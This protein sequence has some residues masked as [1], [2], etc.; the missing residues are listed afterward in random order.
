MSADT[1]D[2]ESLEPTSEHAA[3]A[4]AHRGYSNVVVVGSSAGG[5]EAL[6]TILAALPSDF[7][8]PIVIAQHLDP[9]RPSQLGA[10]LERKST[11]PVSVV[12]KPTKLEAG[13]AYVVASNRHV[14]IH[15]GYVTPEGDH[16]GRPRPSIDLLLSTAAASY[17]ENLIAV[18]LTGSGSDGAA[19]AL[20]VK[21]QGGTIVIQNP[22]TARFPSMPLALPPTAVDH[23][24][25]LE[26]I[27]ALLTALVGGIDLP[28]GDEDSAEGVRAILALVG[29][30]TGVD[31]SAYKESTIHR[32]LVRRMVVTHQESLQSYHRYL[33][34]HREE[35]Q[36]LAVAFLIKV[37][38]FF[39]DAEAFAFLRERVLPQL[40][41]RGRTQGRVLR[42]WSAG[43]A[44]G[45]EPYSLA[46]LVADMLGDEL[47]EWSVKIFATDLDE[48]S[49]AFARRGLYPENVLD[50][51]PEDYARRFFERSDAG[52]MVSKQL[53]QMV[54]YGQQDIGKG[55]PFPRLDLVV[56]RNLLIYFK[57]ELQQHVL[58]LFAYSLSGAAGYMFLGKAET[59]RPASGA[60][61][62]ID[63]RW[64]VYRC[65]RPALATRPAQQPPGAFSLDGRT[66][67][68]ARER[69]VA[70][71][72][73]PSDPELAQLRRFN[74]LLLRLVAV[75]VVVVDRN[76]RLVAINQAGRRLLGVRELGHEQDFLHAVRG[77]PYGA[78]REAI[79]TVFREH[80]VAQLDEI[81]LDSVGG[82]ARRFL[83]LSF[84]YAAQESPGGEVALV[85]VLDGSEAV[86]ARHSLEA[87]RAEQS[88][89]VSELTSANKRLSEMNKDL[90]DANE[91][92]QATNEEMT[93][94][95]EELQ[96]SNEELEAT[97][98][99]IQATNEELETNNEE[100]QATN[101]ELEAT[102]DELSARTQELQ[103]VART[104]SSERVRLTEMIELAPM[105]VLV[106]RGVS[107]VLE[108]CN[109]RFAKLL[110]GQDWL[111]HPLED[112][113]RGSDF[114]ALVPPI[115]DAFWN[116]RAS[117]QVHVQLGPH[118][119][120][121]TIVPT[122]DAVGKVD[123]VVV[124]GSEPL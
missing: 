14:T 4:Q 1:T 88:R 3:P 17:G 45:E 99:E 102:N 15:D 59:A 69:H 104:L 73:S 22:E 89:L 9:Q 94:T 39:R 108:A 29:T 91:E 66:T 12:E 109:P 52:M 84:A 36:R 74:E 111:D 116:D 63:K 8:A 77:L 34:Q 67:M 68:R 38:E 19:G 122:H 32:R 78:V 100:L 121:C 118:A 18:I 27:P 50:K 82:S 58:D 33:E 79:D 30:A 25:D 56:C 93:L 40:I 81:E 80:G 97:N 5:I 95:Q 51:L 119:L 103:E 115:R 46:M 23:V 20:D 35:V 96:A 62:M 72:P 90:Q 105:H 2:A 76:Y 64:K 71:A 113:V 110:E 70:D 55:V 75:G 31:F 13:R 124:F 47:P 16:A 65:T 10:V 123:G 92:L 42:M 57:P 11:I 54:I 85:T 37:T 107:L 41:E 7:A 48:E 83:T 87:I 21:R 98:E 86:N 114:G 117:E 112:V 106:L 60:F 26:Q 6:V 53:R 43:C 61:E 49:I 24:A 120:N 101:E 28:P 44:T